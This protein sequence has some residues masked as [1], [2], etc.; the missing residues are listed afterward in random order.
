MRSGYDDS[1]RHQNLIQQRYDDYHDQYSDMPP[2]YENPTFDVRD[3]YQGQFHNEPQFYMSRGNMGS[4]DGSF[5]PIALPQIAYGDEQPFLR[6]YTYDLSQY[7]ISEQQFIGLLDAINVAIIPN[8]ENQIFQKGA[9]IAGWFLPGAASIGLTLGQIG[10]GLGTSLGHASAVARILST[11]NLQLFLPKGLEICIGKTEDVNNEVGLAPGSQ[12]PKSFAISPEERRAYFGSLI[13]PLSRVLPPLQQNGRSD[14][15]AMLGR[16]L[17]SRTNQKKIE[18]AEKEMAKGKKTKNVDS[19]EGGL[20]WLIVRQA[21]ADALVYWRN[22]TASSV[23]QEQVQARSD[24]QIGYYDSRS[25]Q[26]GSRDVI[27][28]SV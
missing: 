21:S 15:I 1:A 7:G 10:V 17:A 6:G 24:S 5:H 23:P 14:P 12:Q 8:P 4:I 9:N 19:L 22:S 16:G 26:A 13:A 18:K 3:S 20:R 25:N 28:P 27:S 11:A 2:R